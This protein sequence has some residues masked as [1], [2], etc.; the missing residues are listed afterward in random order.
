MD[1]K[2]DTL[3]V[4]TLAE[5]FLNDIWFIVDKWTYFQKDTVG[6]QLVRSADSISANIAEGYGRH[7][8]GESQHFYYYS[9]GSMTETQSWLRKAKVRMM[10]EENDYTRLIAET[11]TIQAKLNGYIKWLR[12]EKSK[13]KATT[14]KISQ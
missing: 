11:E 8:Y 1:Y 2:L 5:A 7:F 13:L 10:I 3:S 12:S 14:T 4:Y 6:K 9:R